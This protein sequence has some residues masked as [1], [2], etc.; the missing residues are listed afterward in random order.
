VAMPSAGADAR[1]VPNIADSFKDTTFWLAYLRHLE[2]ECS[3]AQKL[4]HWASFTK[5][6]TAR[7][8]CKV[9]RQDE[10]LRLSRRSPLLSALGGRGPS[11]PDNTRQREGAAALNDAGRC[12][13]DAQGKE[14]AGQRS[15]LT[16]VL[17]MLAGSNASSM[18]AACSM[19]IQC[20]KQWQSQHPEMHTI[21]EEALLD[22]CAGAKGTPPVFFI[23]G[24]RGYLPE[25]PR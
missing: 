23:E 6:V 9:A 13:G 2:Q 4:I 10:T 1:P 11:A 20:N 7:W 5:P 3:L 18:D 25:S 15:G 17:L 14:L 12:W 8:I 22:A 21:V 24:E 16:G 19:R